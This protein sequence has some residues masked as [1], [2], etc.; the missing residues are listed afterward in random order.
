[1]VAH[2]FSSNDDVF[3]GVI[4]ASLHLLVDKAIAGKLSDLASN[5]RGV[6]LSVEA[7]YEGNATPSLQHAVMKISFVA[8]TTRLQTF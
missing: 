6:A 4:K 3:D 7:V 5:A 2:I 1:M 8:S